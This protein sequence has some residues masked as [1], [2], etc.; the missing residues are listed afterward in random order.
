MKAAANDGGWADTK[1]DMKDEW[2][3]IPHVVGYCVKKG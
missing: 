2:S 1:L 3:A